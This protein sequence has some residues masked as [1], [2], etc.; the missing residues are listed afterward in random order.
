[1]SRIW[2][3]LARVL[4]ALGL[5]SILVFTQ[6]TQAQGA[7]EGQTSPTKEGLTQQF[8]PKER[9]AEAIRTVEKQRAEGLI[10]DAAYTKRTKM[11]QERQAGAY[12]PQSLS[13]ENPPLNFI[14][15][16][17]FEQVNKNS[18]KNRSRWLWWGGWS[19]GGDYENSW[20][21]RAEHV[22]SG[23]F[24][25][26]ITCTGQKGRIGISTPPLPSIPGAQEYKLTFWAQGEGDNML[27]VN[28][29]EGAGGVLREKI[30]G[31]WKQYTVSGKPSGNKDTYAVYLYCIGLGTIWLD[32]VELVPVGGKM[33]E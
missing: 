31:E 15:N 25:A 7:K 18:A 26:R 13:V 22:H 1:M 9:I 27:F 24:S 2:I 33:E 8:W 5:C 19:W 14:Q 12:Q 23:K 30:G 6:E 17:S 3:G 28:F 16:G 21:E 29:E 10:S 20:E 11:L 4:A 32:D